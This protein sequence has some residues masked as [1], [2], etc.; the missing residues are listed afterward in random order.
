VG[1]GP[2]TPDKIIAEA[3]RAGLRLSIKAGQL[4]VQGTGT[5]PAHLLEAIRSNKSQIL[6]WL[7]AEPHVLREGSEQ[8]DKSP[9]PEGGIPRTDLPLPEVLPV[10]SIEDQRRF[11][12]LVL[13]QGK[14]AI[15]WCLV[16]ANAYWLKFPRS[17]W[18][19]QDAAAANDLLRWQANP[20]CPP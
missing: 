15:G 2:L 5:R 7:Q 13:K 4:T 17:S 19:E 11:I 10:V 8:S 16:R 3:K 6:S 9:E 14:P 18:V 12:D 20:N 1:G